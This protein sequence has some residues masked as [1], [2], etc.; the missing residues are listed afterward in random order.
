MNIDYL[1]C[2]IVKTFAF[3]IRRLPL[4]WSL[5]IGR[6]LGRLGYCFYGRRVKVSLAN[7]RMALADQKSG[8]I[9]ELPD[10]TAEKK[11]AEPAKEAPKAK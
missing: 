4:S 8:E 10:A 11:L 1:G 3:F 5:G 7:L 6:F 2:I 9:K